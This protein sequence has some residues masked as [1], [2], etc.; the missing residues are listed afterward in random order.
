MKTVTARDWTRRSQL[1]FGVAVIC[2]L[3]LVETAVAH[4]SVPHPASP[5][6]WGVL[7]LVGVGAA[8]TAV[9]CR[10]RARRADPTARR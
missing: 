9:V 8:L 7:G 3:F 1:C 10:L 6:I 4:R 2:V 5:I